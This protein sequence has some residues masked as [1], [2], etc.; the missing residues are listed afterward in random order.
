LAIVGW[1]FRDVRFL[2]VQSGSMAPLI[3]RGDAVVVR[4][5]GAGQLQVGEI[6]SYRSPLDTSVVVTHRIVSMHPV[7]HTLVT[8]GDQLPEPDPQ[9]NAS[10]VV[11]HAVS[12][13]PYAG[14]ALDWL[15][16]PYGLALAVYSPAAIIVYIE[17]KRLAHYF[18]RARYQRV[19]RTL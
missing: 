19:G 6:I 4:A 3:Q 17:L 8:Q 18:A 15:H 12:T 9:I 7:A 13:V 10:L 14:L 16:S 5:K 1:Q 11:G 2:S